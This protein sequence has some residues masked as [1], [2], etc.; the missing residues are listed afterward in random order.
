MAD[1]RYGRSCGSCGRPPIRAAARPH[2]IGGT[3]RESRGE[4]C[5]PHPVPGK[6]L[7]R[8]EGRPRHWLAGWL[9]ACAALAGTVTRAGDG[10]VV[11]FAHRPD[12]RQVEVGIAG[13]PFA[14]YDYG[15]KYRKPFFWPV[16][17]ADGTV[18]SRP[19]LRPGDDHPHHKGLWVAVDEVNG[20]DFWA[21]KGKIVNQHIQTIPA[22]GDRPARLKVTNH[23]QSLDGQTVVRE[24]TTFSFFP[25]RMIVL[26]IELQAVAEQVTFD[27]TKEGFAGFRM[28]DS[29]REREG[30]HVVNAE[31]LTGTK[32]CWGKTSKWVDYYGPV[33]G[34]TYGVTW[35]DHPGNFRPSRYHV[36]D[37]GL[38]AISPFGPRAYSK[39][40][41][42][43]SPVKLKRGETLRIRYGFYV[44]DGDTEQGHVREA[45]Q[46]FL[47]RTAE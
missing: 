15:S 45:Y 36:R 42:P 13:R 11:T 18:L 6:R 39:G 27:D 16:R 23:W 28:V 34:K 35:F 31:G 26:D 3:T 1:P 2:W 25:D 43:A 20:I 47:R 46:R 10:P 29:M 5:R 40:K 19:L 30:G 7:S 44:H 33:R 32:N 41:L 37:Y 8:R 17:A 38:F 9:V 24:R 4:N 21:E 12:A 14:V 22:R